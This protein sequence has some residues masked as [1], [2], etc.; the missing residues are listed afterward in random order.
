MVGAGTSLKELL[1]LKALEAAG[2]GVWEWDIA[3]NEIEWSAEHYKLFGNAPFSIAPNYERWEAQVHPEDLPA[4]REA[5]RGALELG[6]EY[7]A[8]YRALLPDGTYRWILGR[9]KAEY[10]ESGQPVRMSGTV[11]DITAQQTKVRESEESFLTYRLALEAGNLGIFEY[12][13]KTQRI[14]WSDS[15]FKMFGYEDRFEPKPNHWLDRIH[16]D[17]QPVVA[18]RYQRLIGKI[19]ELRMEYRIVWPDGSIHWIENRTHCNVDEDG[20]PTRVFGVAI[21]ITERKTAERERQKIQE[22]MELAVETGRMAIFEHDYESGDLFW[23]DETFEMFGYHEPIKPT[24]TAWSQ[25]VHPDDRERLKQ[26]SLAGMSSSETMIDEYRVVLPDGTVRWLE[27]RAKYELKAPGEPRRIFGITI[28]IDDRKRRELDLEQS[29]ATLNLALEASHVGTY[30]IDY[31]NQRV[32]LCDRSA[33]LFGFQNNHHPDLSELR[34]RYHPD[35]EKALSVTR[36]TR[37]PDKPTF[38]TQTRI[39]ANGTYRW[40][41]TR[42]TYTFDEHARP[43]HLTAVAI[44]VDEQKKAEVAVRDSEEKFRIMADQSPIMMYVT[45]QELGTIFLNPKWEEFTGESAESCYGNS[46]ERLIHSEDLPELLALQNQSPYEP[47]R[48]EYRLRRRDGEYRWCASIA[49]PRFSMDGEL[50]GRIGTIYDIHDAKVLREELE[51]SVRSRTEELIAAN[52][53]MEGFTYTV[54]HDLRTPLRAIT[55]N[56]RI[57]LEDYLEELPD[58]AQLMLH[59]QAD[60]ATRMGKLIDDLLQYSRIG[61]GELHR[62]DCN[63]G[64][65]ADAAMQDALA[66]HAV[67]LEFAKNGNLSAFCDPRLM[68]MVLTNLFS[69]SIKFRSPERPLCISLDLDEHWSE[70]RFIV[71]DNGVGFDQQYVGKIFLP[72]ERLVRNEEFPGTGIGLANVARIIRRHGGRIWAEGTLG[73]GATFT[74][75]LP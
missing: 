17:D 37:S 3:T 72:F 56:S 16:P 65:I 47:Y 44:D 71:S 59:R 35:D 6:T 23:S 38:R 58:D 70:R 39:L 15:H 25:R 60:A 51:A 27:S 33:E 55:S 66:D 48:Q 42:G 69:N 63:L 50:I 53:E 54:A 7:D 74:F 14:E 62:V 41:E 13:V 10:S 22:T 36:T 52:K 26:H 40:V 11:M 20:K 12:D 24:P 19:P 28:D 30:R 18:E 34:S 29:Q 57:L 2:V 46:W 4:V 61:R 43:L 45:D 32:H 64:D 68:Q 1:Y 67:E 49:S 8:R 73:E 21:D 31:V 5:I 75:T 9:G